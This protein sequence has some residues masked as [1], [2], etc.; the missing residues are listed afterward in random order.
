[1][2][3][4]F[5]TTIRL[6]MIVFIMAYALIQSYAR[7][8]KIKNDIHNDQSENVKMNSEVNNSK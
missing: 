6:L 2:P 7:L 5:Y 8:F 1:M 3:C 4:P